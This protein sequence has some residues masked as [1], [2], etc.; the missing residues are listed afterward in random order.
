MRYLFLCG[1]GHGKDTPQPKQDFP[2]PIGVA[3]LQISVSGIK[4]KPDVHFMF[5]IS[6]DI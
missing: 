6:N 2:C 5:I 4:K 1:Q 3:L